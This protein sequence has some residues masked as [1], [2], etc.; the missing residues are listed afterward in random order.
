MV[1]KRIF[2]MAFSFP[3]CFYGECSPG[4][5]LFFFASGLAGNQSGPVVCLFKVKH[6]WKMSNIYI[7][8]YHRRCSVCVYV[9]QLNCSHCATHAEVI[10]CVFGVGE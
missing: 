8:I 5:V 9:L 10:F 4:R 6:K 1:N 2:L 3:P 7:Y